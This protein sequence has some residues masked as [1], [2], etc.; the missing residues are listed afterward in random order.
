MPYTLPVRP[1][2]AKPYFSYLANTYVHQTWSTR[3]RQGSRLPLRRT[4]PL[5]QKAEYNETS[6]LLQLHQQKATTK[7][8]SQLVQLQGKIEYC[9]G[10]VDE[11]V[12]GLYGVTEEER[13]VVEGW[14]WKVNH[15]LKYY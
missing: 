6:K 2:L 4:T 12:Y 15:V 9:E 10:R 8:E 11:L 1:C 14:G 5:L 3:Y 7:L 13:R